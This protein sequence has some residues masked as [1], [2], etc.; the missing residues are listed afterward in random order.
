MAPPRE[1]PAW[2][3]TTP[4]GNGGHG[5]MK[6]AL[7]LLSGVAIGFLLAWMWL[8]AG[9]APIEAP[10]DAPA[11]TSADRAAAEPQP[12]TAATEEPVAPA[13]RTATPAATP[14]APRAAETRPAPATGRLVVR[15]TPANAAVV[16]DRVWSGRTPFTRDGIAFGRHTVRVVLEGYEPVNR[17]I[18]ISSENPTSELTFTLTRSARRPATPIAGTTGTLTVSSRPAGARVLVDGRQVGT[19]PLTLPGVAAGSRRIRVELAGYRPWTSTVAVA[20]NQEARVAA[21]LRRQ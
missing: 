9:R 19:T 18:T 14:A 12:P 1:V 6:P 11:E 2:R 17:Q 4:P 16:I 20:R 15:S 13:P 7:W 21:T 10:T 3:P 5:L 8:G